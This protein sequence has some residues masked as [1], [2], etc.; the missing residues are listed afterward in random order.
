MK[1][2]TVVLVVLISVLIY[3]PSLTTF[4]SA[5][6]WFHLRVSQ[7]GTAQQFANFFSFVRN[8]ESIAFYRP[9]STQVFF[10]I[11]Q[12]SF[13]LNPLPYHAFV[14]LCFGLS[15][16]LINRSAAFLLSSEKKALL[17][18]FIYG[19]S[20]SN[21][22][23]LYFLSAFQEIAMVNF[24]LLCILSY[25]YDRR[26]KSL[27][28]FILALLSKET[29]IVIPA[30]LLV[31]D[32]SWKKVSLKKL[33]P[34][35]LILLPYLYFRL[36]VFGL[37]VGDTYQWNFSLTKAANTL[38]WYG[39]WSVGAPELLVDYI[40]SGFRPIARFFSD[41]S[42]WWGVILGLLLANLTILASLV[43]AMRRKLNRAFFSYLFL[44]IVSL[45]PVL[46]FPQH[47]FTLELGLPLVWFC[48]GVVWLMPIRGKS[49]AIFVI[50]FFSLNLSMNYLSYT[51]HPSVR[52]AKI[53]DQVLKYFQANFPEKPTDMYF[54]FVND[55][56]DY[57]PTWGSSKQISN[58]IGGSELF[59]VMYHD[60]KYTVFYEDYNENRPSL[61][62][63]PI[64]SK[65]F[66][67]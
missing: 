12:K 65:I 67:Q 29:A 21:F 35:A 33:T 32:W 10:F 9:L 28:F 4:F 22:T 7:I 48:L 23:R 45:S 46:F 36:S 55:T 24:S 40:G 49:L 17:V 60:P 56:A 38:M 6:D 43:F 31:L 37:A 27:F 2:Y 50:L 51:K 63:I 58:S 26:E 53:S 54:E 11:F 57:G 42:I 5:D 3:L 30:I 1:R 59:R 13:G 25:L 61:Q 20:V 39:L 47:K 66:L 8:P 16:F 44:F 14:L 52:R 19:F 41:F 15:L 18:I 62:R 34:F 64:S